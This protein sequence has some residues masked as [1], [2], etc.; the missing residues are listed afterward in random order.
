MNALYISFVFHT[1]FIYLFCKE[2]LCIVR[3][4]FL[5]T[6][7]LLG[8]YTYMYIFLMYLLYT[9]YIDFV[10]SFHRFPIYINIFRIY[11]YIYMCILY[12]SY[13]IPICFLYI[14]I[15]IGFSLG[16]SMCVLYSFYICSINFPI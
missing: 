16:F 14:N 10:Y 11:I 7:F 2:F 15:C 4:Y 9:S 6:Y 8:S 13:E 5:Y 1:Y 12:S 3:I